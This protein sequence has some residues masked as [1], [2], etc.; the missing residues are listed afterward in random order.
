MSF[1]LNVVK[2]RES[3]GILDRFIEINLIQMSFELNVV[4]S[5]ESNGILDRIIL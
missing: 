4:K 2:W 5:L 1:E 3:N